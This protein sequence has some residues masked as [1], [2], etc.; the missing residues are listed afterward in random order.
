MGIL[1][2]K[3]KP[4]NIFRACDMDI[5]LDYIGLA[6]SP[7]QPGDISAPDM[8]RKSEPLSGDPE[9]IADMIIGE[10]KKAGIELG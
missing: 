8:N 10:I 7:T 2:A 4:L 6:G 9:E 1:K 3:N 5:N